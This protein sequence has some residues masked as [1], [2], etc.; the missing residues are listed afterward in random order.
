V[1]RCDRCNSVVPPS[2][3]E[4]KIVVETRP[5]VYE[6]RGGMVREFTRSRRPIGKRTRR[7]QAFDK[8]GSGHEIVRE[9]AVCPKCAEAHKAELAATAETTAAE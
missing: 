4:T 5:K 8:G 1:F 7:A 2:T 3:R 9:I 6:S